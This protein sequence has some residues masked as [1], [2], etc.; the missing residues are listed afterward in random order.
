MT[1]S[2]STISVAIADDHQLFREGM[3]LILDQSERCQ[4]MLEA[5]NGSEFLKQLEAANKLPHVALL[6]LQMPVMDG[7]ETLKAIVTTYPD[8]KV[9]MLSMIERE[10]L[11]LHLL[12]T[13]AIGYLLKNSS[14]MEVIQ[15]IESAA[16][17][18][19]YFNKH[20][21]EVLL[22]GLRRKRKPAPKLNTGSQLTERER[23][24]LNLMCKELTT[25]QIADKLFVSVRTIETHRKNLM[26]KLEAKNMAGVVYRA[27]KEGILD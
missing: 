16:E 26:D 5:S 23:E 11:I 1:S 9:L 8:I 12:D 18:G 13:G 17:T 27:M 14:A 2:K 15:A 25:S 6:D 10:D 7:M 19:F 3:R 22:G 4:L 24:V 21:S 20:V